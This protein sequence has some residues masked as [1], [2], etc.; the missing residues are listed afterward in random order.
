MASRKIIAKKDSAAQLLSAVKT[1]SDEH[2]YNILSDMRLL[3]EQYP[4]LS[5][6]DFKRL[7]S[8]IVEKYDNEFATVHAAL[9]AKCKSGDVA[10]IKLYN[11]QQAETASADET[12]TI[13]DDI[14]QG[15]RKK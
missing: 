4:K 5:A 15:T 8:A 12:V 7:L 14:K 10:A 3:Q 1:G 9:V 6:K 2:E 13:I 11:E